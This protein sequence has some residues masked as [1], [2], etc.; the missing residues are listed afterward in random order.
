M[1]SLQP[2]F[3]LQVGTLVLNADKSFVAVATALIPIAERFGFIAFL[4]MRVLQGVSFASIFPVVGLVTNNWASLHE[5][6]LFVS[7]LTGFTQLANIFTMPVSGVHHHHLHLPDNFIF[8]Q[9]HCV[10]R[11]HSAGDPYIICMRALVPFYLLCGCCIF[12]IIQMSIDSS[13]ESSM[14]E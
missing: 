3:Y 13:D 6:G 10:H 4:A 7:L 9:A 5:H 2:A 12:A 11:Q 8:I 1:S 14:T